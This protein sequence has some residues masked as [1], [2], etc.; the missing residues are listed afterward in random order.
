MFEGGLAFFSEYF[1]AARTLL[2]WADE[3]R[4]P[5]GERLPEYTDVRR[6]LYNKVIQGKYPPASTWKLAASLIALQDSAN[7]ITMD[8]RM[9][10]P[11]TGARNRPRRGQRERRVRR[12]RGGRWGGASAAH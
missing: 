1:T 8:T 12:G 11:C 7:P 5:N 2:R 4:K 6:P 9:P 10:T 3:S